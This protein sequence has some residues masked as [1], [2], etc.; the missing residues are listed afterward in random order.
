METII[1]SLAVAVSVILFTNKLGVLIERQFGWIFG[2]IG[3]ILAIAYLWL[4]NMPI[5]MTAEIGLIILMFYGLFRDRAVG[6]NIQ[7]TMI[8]VTLV[9][10]LIIAIFA[11][12]GLL[13]WVEFIGS[14]FMLCAV[15]CL[16]QN[17][18]SQVNIRQLGWL[19]LGTSHFLIAYLGYQKDEIF[20]A[21]FQ[22]ASALVSLVGI[23]KK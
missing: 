12:M 15:Y 6:R 21:D 22:I 19:L 16:A 8:V 23:I 17:N 10:C 7:L 9:T 2:V 18:F 11:S 1:F 20:F 4:I 3:T 5:L 13:T 14:G